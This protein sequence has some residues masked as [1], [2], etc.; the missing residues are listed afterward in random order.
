MPEAD[1]VAF[2]AA[3]TPYYADTLGPLLDAGNPIAIG[4]LPILRKDDVA[5][6]LDDLLAGSQTLQPLPADRPL[7][8]PLDEAL[9]DLEIDIGLEQRQANFAQGLFDVPLTDFSLTSK[10]FKGQIQFIG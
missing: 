2:A 7:P 3:H 8:D 1:I 9:D 10:L 4:D 6:R 5:R